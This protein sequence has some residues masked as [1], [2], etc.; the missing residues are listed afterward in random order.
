MK[1]REKIDFAE[2]KR[3]AACVQEIEKI[4]KIVSHH[5]NGGDMIISVAITNGHAIDT[6]NLDV[7]V[8]ASVIYA[9]SLLKE[10]LLNTLQ[11]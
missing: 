5:A 2:I 10:D 8:N 6:F 7:L 11:K 4:E 9:L 3:A 1:E